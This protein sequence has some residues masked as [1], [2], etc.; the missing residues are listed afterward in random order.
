MYATR[1]VA[2]LLRFVV[3]LLVLGQATAYAQ[4]IEVESERV[5]LAMILPVLDGTE[6]GALDV[7]PAPPPGETSVIRS[8]DVRAKLRESGR[9]ARGLAIPKSVRIVRHKKTL[10]ESEFDELVK[11]ALAPRVA[12]CDIEQLSKLPELTLARGEFEL[13]AESLTRKAS[14]RTNVSVKLTQGTRVQRISAQA[15]L[16]CPEPVVMPGAQ[17]RLVVNAGPVH[18]SAPGVVNQPG[19][20]GD[21]VRVTNQLTKKSLKARVLDA[22]TVEVLR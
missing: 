13:E 9:D 17:V 11:A 14:G 8:S 22:Q 5:T 1:L 2:P 12:P 10:A 4:D 3:A 20:V 7:A 15:V 16:V 19:R 6:L 21:E 18:V